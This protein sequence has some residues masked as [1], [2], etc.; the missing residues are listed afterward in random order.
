M[1]EEGKPHFG[2]R[3]VC[4]VIVSRGQFAARGL[5]RAL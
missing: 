2:P 5:G 4:F 3:L 1:P